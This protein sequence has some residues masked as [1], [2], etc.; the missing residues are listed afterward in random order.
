MALAHLIEE[1][2][3][4]TVVLVSFGVHLNTNQEEDGERDTKQQVGE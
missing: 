3:R 2:T 4:A 1:I